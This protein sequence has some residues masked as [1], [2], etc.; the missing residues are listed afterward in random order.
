MSLV[1][2][3]KWE[4]IEIKEGSPYQ[5]SISSGVC[6]ISPTEICI[7]GGNYVQ[8]YEFEDDCDYTDLNLVEKEEI[9]KKRSRDNLDLLELNSKCE[10]SEFHVFYHNIATNE[11]IKAQVDNFP[12]ACFSQTYLINNKIFSFED[13][14]LKDVSRL[15]CCDIKN[16][17]KWLT[18]EIIVVDP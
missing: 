13:M 10:A 15:Y 3:T 16:N 17:R 18:P 8:E 12:D 6:Q 7:F 2:K 5:G 14:D 11:F 4:S 9:T 1:S